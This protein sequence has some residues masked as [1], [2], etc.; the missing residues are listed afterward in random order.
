MGMF[1]TSVLCS[2]RVYEQVGGLSPPSCQPAHF[3]LL[4]FGFPFAGPA[5]LLATELAAAAARSRLRDFAFVYNDR[6]SQKLKSAEL[7]AFCSVALSPLSSGGGGGGGDHPGA[8]T[9][10]IGCEGPEGRANNAGQE[11]VAATA[12]LRQMTTQLLPMSLRARVRVAEGEALF[13]ELA[14]CAAAAASEEAEEERARGRRLAGA[15]AHADA[16]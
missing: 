12:A 16:K 8:L 3:S 13:E 7:L 14:A 10:H 2:G 1:A 5:A 6:A 9:L 15:A 11:A 4:Y